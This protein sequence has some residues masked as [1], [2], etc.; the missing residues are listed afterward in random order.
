MTEPQQPPIPVYSTSNPKFR[1]YNLNNF[2]DIPQIANLTEQ[3]RFDIE[4]VGHVLPFKVNNYVIDQLIIWDRVPDDP[5]FALTFPQRDMLNPEHY[6]EMAALLRRGADK[7]EISEAANRIRMQL[8]PHPAGQTDH[9][10]PEMDG[11]RLHGMQHKYRQTVLFF[12][13]QGQ[14]CHAYCTFCFRWPQF[15]GMN[16]IKFASRE[17]EKLVEYVKRNPHVTDILFTGGDPMIM[18]AKNLAAYIE[19]LLSAE[20]PNLVNIRIGTKAL[21]YWPH[22]FVDDDDAQEMLTLFRRVTDSGKQ[23]ALMAHFNHP[24][25]LENATVRRAIRNL[26]EADVTIRTQSP[27][28][29]HINDDPALW[30]KMWEEQVRLGCVPYYMFLARDTGAQHYFSVP[31]V[32]AWQIFREAYQQVSGLA[33]TVR[34]PSMSANPGKIQMLGVANAGSQKVLVMRF[35]QG[36]NPDWVQRPFFAEHNESATWIDE[37]KPAF[38]EEKFFFEEELEQLFHE[39]NDSSTADDFE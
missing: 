5:I 22:K 12:P 34:G 36:R 14:T 30:A 26:R 32:R 17:V 15:I 20:L 27:V 7:D 19:P 28:M 10:V 13:S 1:S 24:R 9:N 38:G 6:E 16:D 29:R 3:Q 18:T 8:N 31:L 33:R 2:R 11:E 23:L 21:A 25:E 4:V 37:L 39:C 35:L